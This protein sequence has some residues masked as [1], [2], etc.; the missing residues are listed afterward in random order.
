MRWLGWVMGVLVLA[1]C[2]STLDDG[3]EPHKL[4]A[5]VDDRKAYYADPFTADA[6]PPGNPNDSGN[7][8]SGNSNGSPQYH[9]PGTP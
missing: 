9:R 3:Y 7:S 8:N 6:R 2:G 5:G 4:N 1:G